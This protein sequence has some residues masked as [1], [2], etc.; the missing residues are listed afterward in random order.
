MAERMPPT[1]G[2]MILIRVQTAA[3]PIVPAPTKRTW[4]RNTRLTVAATSAPT[5]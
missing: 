1:I 5:P 2:P 3:T 4:L